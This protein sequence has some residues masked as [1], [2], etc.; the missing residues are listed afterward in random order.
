M[1]KVFLLSLAMFGFLFMANAQ[2]GEC[3]IDNIPGAYI[4][5]TSR[6]DMGCQNNSVNSRFEIKITAY[7]VDEK[8]EGAVT[9]VVTYKDYQGNIKKTKPFSI[10]YKNRRGS[11]YTEC[12]SYA[13]EVVKIEIENSW[14]SARNSSNDE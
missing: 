6:H 10:T 12:L 1:K 3:K 7:G 5:A 8:A 14:C 9:C 4:H 13:K 2:T 11:A